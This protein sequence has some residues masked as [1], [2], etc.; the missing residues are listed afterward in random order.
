MT[1]NAAITH[2]RI[3][4]VAGFFIIFVMS[5]A[6]PV[7]AQRTVPV[8][9][10]QNTSTADPPV[11]VPNEKPCVVQLY[12]NLEFAD[13]SAKTYEYTPACPGPWKKVVFSGDFNVTAGVQFDRTA[14]VSLGH[15]N[16]Y[17]G[18]T[19]EPSQ[20]LGPSWHVERDLTDYSVLFQTSQSGEVD[21]GNLVNSTFTGI[22]FGSASLQFYPAHHDGDRDGDNLRVLPDAVFPLPNAAGGAKALFTTTDQLSET[23]TLP[24][25]IERAY[26]D[27]ISQSQSNDEFW[28]TCVPNDVAGELQ[29][30]G[31][32]G[33]RETEVSV[34]GQAAGIAPVYPWIFTGGIDPFLWAPIPGVQTLNFVPYRVDLTPFAGLLSNGQPHT[35]S[36]SV[37]NADSYFLSTATLLVFLD[38]GSDQVSGELTGNTLTAAPN[39]TVTENLQTD[40]SGDI[41]GSVVVASDRSFKISGFVQTSHGKV[42]TDVLQSVHFN[43]TQNFTINATT[44]V[45]D[46]TQTTGV[47]SRTITHDHELYFASIEAFRYPLTLNI[48]ETLNSDGTI[49]LQTTSEQTFKH[50][51]LDPFFASAVE[52]SVTSTDTLQLDSS[53]HIAGHSGQQS[54]QHF[55]L[56]NSR[57]REYNC[58]LGTENNT[59]T[60][61]SEGCQDT[62]NGHRDH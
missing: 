1:H 60:F 25:N 55:H 8:V 31:N 39:P 18:T 58:A 41:T 48:T 62:G 27:V 46:I 6:R 16:I 34:D 15:I 42:E 40:S 2:R 19:P 13:F 56:A 26:L 4:S 30:C 49:S 44:F 5:G 36:L 59:V 53:F 20:T 51:L 23:F 43:N 7:L 57:G 11:A 10:S 9:G 50:D 38:H 14:Q 22:I 12:S 35:I 45:Q 54:S 24:T 61:V 21:L 28:Y 47:E 52:N 37:F 29:S 33:F 32:S 3:I 17:Y